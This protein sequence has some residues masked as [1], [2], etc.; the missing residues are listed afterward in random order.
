MSSAPPV[1]TESTAPPLTGKGTY[2]GNVAVEG[3]YI[4]SSKGS[5]DLEGAEGTSVQQTFELKLVE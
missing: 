4:L 5:M 1:T 2:E 3:G